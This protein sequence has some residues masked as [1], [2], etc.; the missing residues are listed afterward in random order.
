MFFGPGASGIVGGGDKRV[1]PDAERSAVGARHVG[2]RLAANPVKPGFIELILLPPLGGH[3]FIG[4]QGFAG[5]DEFAIGRGIVAVVGRSELEVGIFGVET[6]EINRAEG[7]VGVNLAYGA[8]DACAVVGRGWFSVKGEGEQS[9]VGSDVKAHALMSDG[10]RAVGQE[11]G[12]EDCAG[13]IPGASVDRGGEGR[14]GGRFVFVARGAEVL[15]VEFAV[16]PSE[17]RLV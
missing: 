13:R 6:Y 5:G 11:E 4:E 12:R 10:R 9:A 16:G 17:H 3:E 8:T 14:V 7:A 15:E 1:F 2:E